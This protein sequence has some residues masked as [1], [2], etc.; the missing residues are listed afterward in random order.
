MKKGSIKKK[1]FEEVFDLELLEIFCQKS[2]REISLVDFIKFFDYVT[3]IV[4][5]GGAEIENILYYANSKFKNYLAFTFEVVNKYFL[6][7]IP[8]EKL[9][10]EKPVLIYPLD[11]EPIIVTKLTTTNKFKINKNRTP[12]F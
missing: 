1:N 11:T 9:H 6:V 2:K 7:V 12:K 10:E 4:V 5:A 3:A 8:K